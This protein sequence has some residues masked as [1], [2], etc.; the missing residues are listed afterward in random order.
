M[1][2]EQNIFI[3]TSGWSY[4]HWIGKFYPREMERTDWIKHLAEHFNSVELNMSFYRFPFKNMLKGWYNKLPDNFQMTMKANRNITHRKRLQNIDELL[5]RFYNLAS[6]LDDK[7]GCILFQTPP[8]FKKNDSN[9][10]RLENFLESLKGNYKNVFEF[11]HK[12]WWSDEIYALLQKY[13]STFCIVSGLNMP[14]TM[15]VTS[16]TVY[17]RFHGPG[18]PYASKYSPKQIKE[19]TEKIKALDENENVENIYC[20]FNNDSEG[21]AIDN[22]MDLQKALRQ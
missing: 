19:W 22:A 1:L 3:G 2:K 13:S 10:E 20:Y 6:V 9:L 21:Y 8:S 5:L 14:D 7:L 12:S 15:P 16:N 17:L 4:D 11:R 18:Q